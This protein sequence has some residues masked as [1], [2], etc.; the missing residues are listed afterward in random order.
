MTE[1]SY[2]TQKDVANFGH[3]LLNV[4]QRAAMHALEPELQRIDR[5][6]AM[7]GRQL[8]V[9]RQRGLY[10][11]LDRESPG[12]REVDSD[13]SWVG[14]LHGLHALSGLPRQR[15]LDNA[16]MRG[17]AHRVVALFRDFLATRGQR[18]P[19]PRQER[20]TMASGAIYTRPQIA[21]L[22]AAHRKGAYAG[23]EAE[24]NALEADFVRAAR[25]GRIIGAKS[26]AG[27]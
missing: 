23:R 4:A 12:W 24:W 15:H 8:A 20:P 19:Q 10:A 16:V 21:A 22:Y 6:N 27:R 26:I 2:L 18:A 17:D 14:W 9:E 25:E 3:E 11:A 7:L 13:P 5:Q 1:R